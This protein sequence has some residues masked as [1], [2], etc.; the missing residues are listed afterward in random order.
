MNWLLAFIP[1][2]FV[3]EYAAASAP[4]IF[5]A[6]ALSLVP[7]AGLIVR[8][9]EQVATYTG[10]ALGGLL[11]ATFGNAPEL[12]I[13]L[14]ALKAGLNDMVRAAI[15]GSI[16]VNLLLALGIAFLARRAAPPH[17]DLQRRGR[18]PLRLADADRRAQPHRAERVQPLLRARRDDAGGSA[19]Q[20]RPRRRAARRLRALSLFMLKTHPD[21]FAGQPGRRRKARPRG[22]RW[23]LPRAL[24]SLL[25]ASRRSLRS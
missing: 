2:T 20:P 21:E 5:F 4:W 3:L 25:V 9:T 19:A 22:P 15:A 17:P 11:N 10:D 23:S 8:S 14:V 18:A 1:V 13:A 24:A 7:I 12:I 16:L 6:A